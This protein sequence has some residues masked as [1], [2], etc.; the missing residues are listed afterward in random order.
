[1]IFLMPKTF[2]YNIRYSKNLNLFKMWFHNWQSVR[3]SLTYF[4]KYHGCNFV[5]YNNILLIDYEN[6]D[7][8]S[9]AF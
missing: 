5:L 8:I 7:K 4:N 9:I 3:F 2:I 6:P 1:M